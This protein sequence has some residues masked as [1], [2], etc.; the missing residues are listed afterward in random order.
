MELASVRERLRKNAQERW[1]E[2]A[3]ETSRHFG[4]DFEAAAR[5]VEEKR[6]ANGERIARVR[7]QVGMVEAQVD[8]LNRM[9]QMHER[10]IASAASARSASL[11]KDEGDLGHLKRLVR[12]A[13]QGAANPVTGELPLELLRDKVTFLSRCLR[14]APFSAPLHAALAA[15]VRTLRKRHPEAVTGK[16]G[17]GNVDRLRGE[18]QA[19]RSRGGW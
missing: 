5:A 15:Q 7:E 19:I 1:S 17:S 3:E 4:E 18:L 8:A 14:A 16:A 6:A 12:G 9:R 2:I 11:R 10:G 13:W